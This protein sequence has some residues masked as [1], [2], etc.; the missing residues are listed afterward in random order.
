M[1]MSGI[2][3]NAIL[4][5]RN[6]V[7]SLQLQAPE[8]CFSASTSYYLPGLTFFFVFLTGFV[9]PSRDNRSLLAGNS[10]L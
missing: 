6:F 8:R 10:L 2:F 4:T 7:L 1:S 5:E 3:I 9:I